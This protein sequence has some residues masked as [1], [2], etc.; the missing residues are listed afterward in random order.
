[1]I[2]FFK[3]LQK[4]PRQFHIVASMVT[5]I[6][7]GL[8]DFLSGF[9]ISFSVFYV[10]AIADAVWFVNGGFG[11]AISCASV[12][13]WLIG[14]VAAGLKFGSPLVP[15]WNAAIM[16][17]SYLVFVWILSSLRQLQRQLE[18]RVR[19]RTSELRDEIAERARLEKEL[20]AISEREQRRIGHDLH[21]SLCQ[22]LTGTAL[23]GEVLAEKLAAKSA[24]DAAD[25]GRIVSLIEDGISL[26]RSL[27]RGLAPV[28]LDA[29]GL[30]AALRELASII[31]GRFHVNCRFI[32]DAPVLVSDATT[33]AHLYRIA[34]EAVSNAIRHGRAQNIIIRFSTCD[35]FIED[36]GTGLAGDVKNSAGMGLR[37]MAHRAAMIGGSFEI[38]PNA[39]G[40]TV[41]HCAFK[42]ESH[43]EHERKK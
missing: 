40:G 6:L 33:S 17:S 42:S 22:H 15:V 10:L 25:A 8:L 39:D 34:Q 31:T 4:L 16:L 12:A 1:M 21:D 36:D 14:D 13:T 9:D 5:V 35:L 43:S 23:A 24:P 2:E 18:Q 38:K 11:I 20:L 7:V 41:V 37:I 3:P 29:E 32:C 28:E 19:E 27:A 30:M 26:A